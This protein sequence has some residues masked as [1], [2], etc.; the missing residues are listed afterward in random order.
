[1]PDKDSVSR[2]PAQDVTDRAAQ[3]AVD[4]IRVITGSLREWVH[5]DLRVPRPVRR[6]I[7]VILREFEIAT[8]R[9]RSDDPPTD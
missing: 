2:P 4:V 1:V 5:E 6:E 3:V 7:E 9:V 8:C